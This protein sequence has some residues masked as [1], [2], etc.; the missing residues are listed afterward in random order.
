MTSFSKTARSDLE[1]LPPKPSR[2]HKRKY[3]T[4]IERKKRSEKI[5][6]LGP[7]GSVGGLCVNAF[8]QNVVDGG[9][10]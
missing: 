7:D 10:M 9:L 2:Q 3:A 5:L 8:L 6:A 4:N 1:V